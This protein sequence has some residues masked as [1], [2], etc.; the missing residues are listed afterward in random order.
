MGID[1]FEIFPDY[2]VEEVLYVLSGKIK[3]CNL[4]LSDRVV[5]L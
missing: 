1:I 2:L 3:T 4:N 5:I